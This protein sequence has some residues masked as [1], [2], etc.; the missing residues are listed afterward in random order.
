MAEQAMRRVDGL[1][2]VTA[3]KL[4]KAGLSRN[5]DYTRPPVADRDRAAHFQ[6]VLIREFDAVRASHDGPWLIDGHYAVPTG[7]GPARIP[8]AVFERL[9]CSH[10]VVVRV[11]IDLLLKR[12]GHRGGAAW[13]DGTPDA[14]SELVHA[15]ADQAV[16]VA[17]HLGVQLVELST[18]DELVA[19]LMGTR[20]H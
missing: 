7:E 6:E 5:E 13:W 19:V 4:I 14:L 10:L 9:G 20:A 12:L 18:P 16:L 8:P 15:D 2:A 11:G 3:G 17:D 1:Q